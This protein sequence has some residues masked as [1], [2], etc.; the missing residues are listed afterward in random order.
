MIVCMSGINP[1][2]VGGL[3]YREG[4]GGK[5]FLFENTGGEL[6]P[7]SRDNVPLDQ[8]P[9]QV[10]A[11]VLG[12]ENY[13]VL[14]KTIQNYR[15]KTVKI[16]DRDSRQVLY[17]API[18]V[19]VKWDKVTPNRVWVPLSNLQEIVRKVKAGETPAGYTQGF[20]N[21]ARLLQGNDSYNPLEEIKTAGSSF[22]I[23][24][25]RDTEIE[26]LAKSRA[27]ESAFR[28]IVDT[29]MNEVVIGGKTFSFVYKIGGNPT[30]LDAMDPAKKREFML[31]VQRAAERAAHPDEEIKKMRFSFTNSRVDKVSIFAND[32]TEPTR[33]ESFSEAKFS[34][35]REMINELNLLARK[36]SG[37]VY[38]TPD[39]PIQGVPR[40]PGEQTCWLSASLHLLAH[41]LGHALERLAERPL[42]YHALSP[43]NQELL[44]ALIKMKRRVLGQ[45]KTAI[46]SQD[47]QELIHLCKTADIR[48][49]FDGQQDPNEFIHMIV[50]RFELRNVATISLPFLPRVKKINLEEAEVLQD[51]STSTLNIFMQRATLV[52]TSKNATPVVLKQTMKIGDNT[53]ELVEATVHD[54]EVIDGK[55]SARGGHYTSYSYSPITKKWYYCNDAEVSEV[56]DVKALLERLSKKATN[57]VYRRVPETVTPQ[58]EEAV[59]KLYTNKPSDPIM[60]LDQCHKLVREKNGSVIGRGGDYLRVISAEN[61]VPFQSGTSATNESLQALA[62]KIIALPARCTAYIPLLKNGSEWVTLKVIKN[63]TGGIQSIDYFDPKGGEITPDLT[64]LASG[65]ARAGRCPN[66]PDPATVNLLPIRKVI[67]GESAKWQKSAAFSAEY[68]LSYIF[69]E[70]APPSKEA[71]EWNIAHAKHVYQRYND[72]GN[73]GFDTDA[74]RPA[75]IDPT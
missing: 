18:P 38:N 55:E 16:E 46:T 21:A 48:M 42:G 43:A 31:A 2:S 19:G 34:D 58:I 66:P 20:L 3:F 6:S 27:P 39:I 72:N 12:P 23:V 75:Y 32:S 9:S 45:D 26:C 37:V 56:R 11:S 62:Q 68:N 52:S 44:N 71:L 63:E 33:S 5:E 65:L 40:R 53:Y 30:S 22:G 24:R 50:D 64:A 17:I 25:Q 73:Y 74:M 35:C 10:A 36:S 8:H 54:G 28:P 15:G 70:T 14:L 67:P 51:A 60:V 59:K 57:L 1:D 7:F 61:H 13:E 49:D 4:S 29:K 69:N 47:I 41:S